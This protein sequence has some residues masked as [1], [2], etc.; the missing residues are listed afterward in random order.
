MFWISPAVAGEFSVLLNGRSFHLGTDEELN[1]GNYGLGLEYELHSESRWKT[2]F[3]M[4]GFVDSNE[5][6]SYMV[7]GGIYRNLFATYRLADFYW[8]AGITGFVMTRRDINGNKPF[9][10]ALPSITFGNR[11]AG[12]NLTYLPGQAVKRL[13]TDESASRWIKGI[14]FLQ[15]KLNTNSFPGSH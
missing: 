15:V 9:P 11:Y 8:D 6:M 13:Y 4:N 1:E 2:R 5:E 14:V 12:F 3:M 10:G 7:G